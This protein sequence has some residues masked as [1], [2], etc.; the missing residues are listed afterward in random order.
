MTLFSIVI[1]D[2][3]VNWLSLTFP[4]KLEKDFLR[5]YLDK[6]LTHTRV[7]LLLAIFFYGIFGILDSWL[8]PEEKFSFWFIRYAIFI[9]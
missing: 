3:E 5:D 9:P 1:S 7:A 2:V 4:G 8:V 6:S